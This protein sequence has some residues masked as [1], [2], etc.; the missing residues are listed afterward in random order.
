M[1]AP[2]DMHQAVAVLCRRVGWP[3]LPRDAGSVRADEPSLPEH[4]HRW[5]H[6]RRQP[7]PRCPRHRGCGET[8]RRWQPRRRRRRA[9][10]VWWLPPSLK[11]I[12][13]LLE[14]E[15]NMLR[16]TDRG[17][18]APAAVEGVDTR[19]AVPASPRRPSPPSPRW[20]ASVRPGHPVP[21]IRGPGHLPAGRCWWR[22]HCDG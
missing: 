20:P 6:P 13:R 8:L 15:L 17:A 12:D 16:G 9:A 1:P 7:A 22:G 2:S 4:S 18:S 11:W 3:R 5:A 19:P 21:R 10:T 14:R